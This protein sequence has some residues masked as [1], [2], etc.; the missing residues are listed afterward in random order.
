ML[1]FL[2]EAKINKKGEQVGMQEFLT[3][4]LICL[5]ISFVPD[6]GFSAILAIIDVIVLY[7]DFKLDK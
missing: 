1:I 6:V 3:V 5:L 2:S 4:A 7:I